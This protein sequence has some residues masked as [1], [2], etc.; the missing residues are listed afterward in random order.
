MPTDLSVPLCVQ[1]AKLV[2]SWEAFTMCGD[3]IDFT[4]TFHPASGGA[5]QQLA[6]QSHD[7]MPEDSKA[8]RHRV[9][10]QMDF[11][12]GDRVVLIVDP[13]ESQ[14]CDGVYIAEFK[15]WPKS[16]DS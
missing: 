15:V 8:Q 7:L 12:P 6:R 11:V 4:A 5:P 14:D 9:E 3:G 1:E 10:R 16:T 2:L 13:R